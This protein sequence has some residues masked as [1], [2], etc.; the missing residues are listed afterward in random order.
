MH[1]LNATDVSPAPIVSVLSAASDIIWRRP[2]I[3][4]FGTAV[5]LWVAASHTEPLPLAPAIESSVPA[6]R[7]SGRIPAAP[8]VAAPWIPTPDTFGFLIFPWQSVVPGFDA[9]P[10]RG[11]DLEGSSTLQGD[12]P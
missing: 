1:A 2:L 6:L 3:L 8:V 12:L 7:V 5:L 9:G 10:A 4:S 11:P